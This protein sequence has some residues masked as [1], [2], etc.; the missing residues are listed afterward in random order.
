MKTYLVKV[1]Q[2]NVQTASVFEEVFVQLH[3][4]LRGEKVSFE[5]YS[6]VYASQSKVPGVYDK[7]RSSGIG[8]IR[9]HG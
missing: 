7:W 5:L 1:P 6:C 9:D 2:G 3:E 8:D 4:T